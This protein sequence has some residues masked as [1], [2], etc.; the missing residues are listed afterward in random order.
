M[1]GSRRRTAGAPRAGRP[2]HVTSAAPTTAAPAGR[3]S[4]SRPGPA[5]RN[6]GFEIQTACPPPR[7]DL[8]SSAPLPVDV[9]SR[10]PP[11]QPHPLRPVSPFERFKVGSESDRTTV[12]SPPP[13]KHVQ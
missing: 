3:P 10:S 7:L 9:L 4:C 6:A 1:D 12:L 11:S 13:I 8:A 2:R 5:P